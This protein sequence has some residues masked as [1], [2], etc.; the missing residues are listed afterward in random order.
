MTDFLS[1][2]LEG[3]NSRVQINL[4]PSS[5]IES[6]NE[7]SCADLSVHTV[8]QSVLERLISPWRQLKLDYAQHLFEDI[9]RAVL[10]RRSADPEQFLVD[11]LTSRELPKLNTLPHHRSSASVVTDCSGYDTLESQTSATYEG[12]KGSSSLAAPTSLEDRLTQCGSTMLHRTVLK[13]VARLL[14]TTRADDVEDFLL[15]RWE[16]EAFAGDDISCSLTEGGTASYENIQQRLEVHCCSQANPIGRL[17]IREAAEMLFSK[18]PANPINFLADYYGSRLGLT[19]TLLTVPSEDYPLRGEPSPVKSVVDM[20]LKR[21]TEANRASSKAGQDMKLSSSYSSM[22]SDGSRRHEKRTPSV[23][24]RQHLA[25]GPAGRPLGSSAEWGGSQS[26]RSD[27]D[28]PECDCT[29]ASRE[30]LRSAIRRQDGAPHGGCSETSSCT[31]QK[32]LLFDPKSTP[33]CRQDVADDEDDEDASRVSVPLSLMNAFRK[34][35]DLFHA[36][37]ELRR[38]L[39][40]EEVNALV[41]EKI[42]RE[43]VMKKRPSKEAALML[44]SANEGLEDA[45]RYLE[46]FEA[47]YKSSVRSMI[48]W[49]QLL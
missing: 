1:L 33:G 48:R 25:V 3:C 17:L 44:D 35:I 40:Q 23:D 31:G 41:S 34:E 21:M 24:N 4:T 6:T 15:T 26:R 5:I 46:E 12:V 36:K 10:T 42:Y 45:Q 22:L 49:V 39:L 37:K 11:F 32:R 13:R 30:P 47:D 8:S 20:Y 19:R 28:E 16:G 7:A 9:G 43:M 27:H 14:L 2:P 18:K 38:N 29:N